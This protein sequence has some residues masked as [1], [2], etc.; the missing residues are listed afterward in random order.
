M[1]DLAFVQRGENRL[2]AGATGCSK[3]YLATAYGYQA[4][5]KGLRVGYYAL[6]ILVQRLQARADGSLTKELAQLERN[7]SII[8][9][10]IT[11]S[12]NANRGA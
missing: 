3:S 12:T 10:F 1:A 6:P 9:T 7:E 4:C 5:L 2:L 8:F 11:S